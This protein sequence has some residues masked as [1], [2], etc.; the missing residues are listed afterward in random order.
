MAGRRPIRP[1]FTRATVLAWL[2]RRGLSQAALAQRIG[3]D[4]GLVSKVLRGRVK[5]APIWREIQGYMAKPESYR[6]ASIRSRRQAEAIE[7][8]RI[9]LRKSGILK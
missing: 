7:K 8:A 2:L 6:P 1:T 9:V 5:S 3:R 4:A